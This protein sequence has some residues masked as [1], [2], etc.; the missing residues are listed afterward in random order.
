MVASRHLGGNFV[1]G[2]VTVNPPTHPPPLKRILVDIDLT[3]SGMRV[4]NIEN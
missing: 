4:K 3:L 1:S 2:E